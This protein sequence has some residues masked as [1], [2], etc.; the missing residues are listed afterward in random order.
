MRLGALA[1]LLGVSTP[2]ASNTVGSLVAK[3]LVAKEPGPDKRS[4]ALKLTP[5][6]EAVADQTAEWPSFLARAVDGLEPA[7]QAVFLRCLV[8]LIR[9]LQENGDIPLQRMC[10]TCRYFQPYAHP[11][12]VN[13]HHCGYVDAAF[14]DRHLRL[15]CA[16]QETA[17]LQE[18]AATWERFTAHGETGESACRAES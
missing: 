6:G 17:P 12:P 16:E 15:N 4:V 1:G 11:D 8:K 7:E 13:P 18:R 2:T 14:G 10:V 5:R 3:D 9:T